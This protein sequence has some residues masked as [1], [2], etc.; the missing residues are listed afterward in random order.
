MPKSDTCCIDSFFFPALRIKRIRLKIAFA[1]NLFV[2]KIFRYCFLNCFQVQSWPISVIK[3][4]HTQI[5]VK[6]SRQLKCFDD[7]STGSSKS[8]HS[9]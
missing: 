2:R 9:L 3:N 7:V 4:I 5:M 8:Q 1:E 6:F